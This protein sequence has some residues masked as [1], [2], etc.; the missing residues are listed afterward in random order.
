MKKLRKKY[1]FYETN[2]IGRG[3]CSSRMTVI[4]LATIIPPINPPNHLPPLH[5]LAL[6]THNG[7]TLPVLESTRIPINV[8]FKQWRRN[9]NRNT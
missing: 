6:E 8:E 7:E 5:S 3:G 1:N 2:K 9:R 4:P